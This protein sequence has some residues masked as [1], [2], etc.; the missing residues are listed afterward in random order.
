MFVG[1]GL[2]LKELANSRG[3]PIGFPGPAFPDHEDLPTLLPK[4]PPISAISFPVLFEFLNPEVT[5]RGRRGRSLAGVPMPETTMNENDLLQS[6]KNQVRTSRKFLHMEP[7]SVSQRVRDAPDD[8][9]RF[10]MPLRDRAHHAAA[11]F[12][13]DYIHDVQGINA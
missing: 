6:R 7:I 4:I 13:G 2:A 12:F 3:E 1:N 10:R 8:H 5:I 9:L 11:R